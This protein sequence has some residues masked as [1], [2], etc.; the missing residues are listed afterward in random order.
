VILVK[1]IYSVQVEEDFIKAIREYS[2]RTGVKQGGLI[3]TQVGPVVGWTK[4]ELPSL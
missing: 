1:K 2:K 4:K 3:E